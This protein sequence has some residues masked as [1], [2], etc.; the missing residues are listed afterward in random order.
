MVRCI[1]N[2]VI[3]IF[4]ENAFEKKE[5]V[6]NDGKENLISLILMIL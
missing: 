5:I 6:I 4:L 1:S 2:R 3:Q